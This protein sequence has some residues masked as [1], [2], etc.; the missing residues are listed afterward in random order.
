MDIGAEACGAK[1]EIR[2]M[3]SQQCPAGGMLVHQRHLLEKESERN[4]QGWSWTVGENCY[5]AQWVK[6]K[7]EFRS[8]RP[9]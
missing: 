4:K 8:T 9:W 1:E 6:Q 5:T 3:D 2:V 7:Q